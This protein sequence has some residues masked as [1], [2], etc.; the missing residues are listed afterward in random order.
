[1]QLYLPQGITALVIMAVS[2]AR[3]GPRMNKNLVE[4][5]GNDLFF[6]K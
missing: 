5:F 1:M 6:K 3:Q 4:K 2:I